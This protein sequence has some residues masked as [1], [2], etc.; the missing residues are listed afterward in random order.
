MQY[1]L[2][3]HNSVLWL[4]GV[5]GVIGFAL[6]WTPVV[7]GVYLAARSYRFARAEPDRVAASTCLGVIVCYVIQAWG[8][9]GMSAAVPTLLLAC[10]LAAAARLASETGAWPNGVLVTSTGSVD[11]PRAGSPVE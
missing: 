11:S 2:I 5:A 8:D 9:I 3:A 7:V 6:I 1:R 10:A 4:L